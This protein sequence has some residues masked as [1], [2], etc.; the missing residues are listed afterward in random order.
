MGAGVERAGGA[1]GHQDLVGYLRFPLHVDHR[2]R[3]LPPRSPGVRWFVMADDDTV[4]LPD[5]LLTVPTTSCMAELGVADTP[6]P[7]L[8]HVR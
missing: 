7:P 3:D 6:G 2:L 8:R 5:N 1:S 4:F